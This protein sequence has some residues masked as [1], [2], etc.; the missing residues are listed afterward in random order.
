[1]NK[2]EIERRSREILFLL[3]QNER[4]SLNQI[5]R[6]MNNKKSQVILSLGTLIKD[7]KISVHESE[8]DLIIEPT[9]SFSNIYY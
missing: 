2:I 3:H 7:G 5:C 8:D 1:M 6:L 4:L 9:Y